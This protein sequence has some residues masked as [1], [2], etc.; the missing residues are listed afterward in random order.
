[1]PADVTI[2]GAGLAGISCARELVARGLHVEVLEA[3]DQVG[4]RVR[5]DSYRGFLLDRGFQILLTAYPECRLALDYEALDLKNFYPGALV[6]FDGKFHRLADP[7]RRLLGAVASFNSGIGTFADK[8]RIAQ[9]RES[10]MRA[11]LHEIFARPETTA[12]AALKERRFSDEM[13]ERFFRPFLAGIFLERNLLTSSRM[14]EFV[15]KMFAE[16]DAAVPAEGMQA[17]PKQLAWGLPIQLHKRVR[18][19]KELNSRAIVIATDGPEAARLAGLDPPK[20]FRGV[21]CFYFA[22]EKPPVQE[23]ILALNG[24]AS[25]PVNN[26]CVIRNAAAKYAPPGASLISASVLGS[27][28]EAEVREHM[29][30]WFGPEVSRWLHLRTYD[31]P[32]A[33]PDQAAPA[34]ADARKPVRIR[35]GLYVC[36]DHIENS[37]LH[38][39]LR[40]GRR[41]TDAVIED[42]D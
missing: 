3:A 5:T 34:L 28:T 4:G 7:W 33:Q 40:S 29:T 31:I 15:F 10:V 38:G 30:L 39:A 14:F 21:R 42:L 2:I 11:P 23:A 32:Y 19:L 26:F 9:L 18:F 12:I 13:I 17:I 16:G 22:A 35:K 41:A 27:G 8:A 25:G 20:T 6:W 1:L 36:G 24:E 37:S